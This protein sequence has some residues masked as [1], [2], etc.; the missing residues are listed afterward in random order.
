VFSSGSCWQWYSVSWIHVI[1]IQ[2]TNVPNIRLAYRYQTLMEERYM[3]LKSMPL[4]DKNNISLSVGSEEYIDE[5]QED[6]WDESYINAPAEPLLGKEPTSPR[7]EIL[8]PNDVNLPLLAENNPALPL[9]PNAM[10]FNED[11]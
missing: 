5:S 4:D 1:D 3:V 7:L 11:Q 2:K 9:I 6:E 8:T 10:P